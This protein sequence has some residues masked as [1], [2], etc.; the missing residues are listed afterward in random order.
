TANDPHIRKAIQWLID[1]QESDGNWEEL[2]YTGTGFPRVFYLK[3]HLY[4][5]YF[6]LMALSR[7]RRLTSPA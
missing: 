1:H 5:L 4:R 7:Y 3:Y 2:W 6:P